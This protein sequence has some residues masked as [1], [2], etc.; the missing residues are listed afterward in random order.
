MGQ[1]VTAGPSLSGCGEPCPTPGRGGTTPPGTPGASAALQPFDFVLGTFVHPTPPQHPRRALGEEASLPNSPSH[2][3]PTLATGLG[4][5]GAR[6]HSGGCFRVPRGVQILTAAHGKGTL[7]ARRGLAGQD[8]AMGSD[9]ESV[10]PPHARCCWLPPQDM[11]CHS[12][13]V[14]YG[15]LPHHPSWG[16]ASTPGAAPPPSPPHRLTPCQGRAG[17]GEAFRGCLTVVAMVSYPARA[18]SPSPSGSSVP[19]GRCTP[20]PAPQHP[21]PRGRRLRMSLAFSW[22]DAGMPAAC[23][24]AGRRR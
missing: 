16:R 23:T 6:R 8:G 4:N 14:W 22:V 17:R 1:A 9:C 19:G 20:L 15:F 21:F 5:P 13:F 10:N 3:H 24:R 18:A 7:E 11:D 2:P 12:S